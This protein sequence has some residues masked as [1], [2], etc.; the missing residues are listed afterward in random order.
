MDH[1]IFT[2]KEMLKKTSLQN[3][4]LYYEF[5]GDELEITKETEN[6]YVLG[7]S[8]DGK[9]FRVI[10]PDTVRTGK[11]KLKKCAYLWEDSYP[12]YSYTF[13]CFFKNYY[14][15]LKYHRDYKNRKDETWEYIQIPGNG[16]EIYIN[17]MDDGNCFAMDDRQIRWI[18][19]PDMA[20][21]HLKYDT[22]KKINVD[23]YFTKEVVSERSKRFSSLCFDFFDTEENLG[24][25]R[26]HFNRQSE[27]IVVTT[28]GHIY[29]SCF[30]RYENRETNRTLLRKYLG[31]KSEQAKK[32]FDYMI[33]AILNA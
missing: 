19:Q 4:K 22:F 7:L 24:Y 14:Y 30:D 27:E 11:L 8:S 28:D 33:D 25:I 18:D 5:S 20:L 17:L 29:E 32:E 31:I 26:I 6:Y 16:N 10:G 1:K 3:P 9:R 13:H 2:V 12:N 21:M 23:K 15:L